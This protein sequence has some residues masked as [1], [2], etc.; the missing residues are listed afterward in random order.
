ML[1]VDGGHAPAGELVEV[2]TLAAPAKAQPG[3]VV[4]EAFALEPLAHAGLHHQV[5][6]ALL[7]HACPD[8]GLDRFA[9]A[10]LDDHRLDAAQVQKMRQHQPGW[11]DANDADL[12]SQ[13]TRGLSVRCSLH[14][15]F[16]LYGRA[17]RTHSSAY[18]AC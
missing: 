11:A 17:K 7:E 12:G 10:R 15:V 4:H 6:G 9:R 2:N 1:R 5:D 13:F 3:A 18:H 8:G 16:G 14:R